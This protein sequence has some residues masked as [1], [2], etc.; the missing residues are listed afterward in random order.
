MPKTLHE[1]RNTPEAAVYPTD[2]DDALQNTLAMLADVE[3]AYA[4][5]RSM[6]DTWSGSAAQKARLRAEFER[7]Y[8]QDRQP[9][10]M[11]LADLH[12][13]LRRVTLFRTLH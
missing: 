3:H 5:H 7:L 4:K 1:S 10:I 12:E 13:R 9:L 2:L 8:Q 6:L 11:R